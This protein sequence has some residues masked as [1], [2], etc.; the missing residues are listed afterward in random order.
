MSWR[1]PQMVGIDLADV[2]ELACTCE[3]LRDWIRQA[4]GEVTQ[5][6]ARHG[7]SP[8]TPAVV[9]EAL[10]R[11]ADL[12]V[13]LVPCISPTRARADRPTPLGPGE[14]LGLGELLIE[15]A[16]NG[17]PADAAHAEAME[18]D[19]RRWALRLT[20]IPGLIP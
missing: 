12:L 2:A 11:F 4:P 15:L 3:F 6:L 1:D 20:R 19:C 18:D 16:A 7:A 8:D 9:V 14:A 5:S 17:W 13:R 10:E